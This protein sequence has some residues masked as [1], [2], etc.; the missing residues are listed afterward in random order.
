VRK[1]PE[2]KR[3]R[4]ADIQINIGPRRGGPG[5]G[6]IAPVKKASDPRK[7]LFRLLAFLG[8]EK[9]GLLYVLIFTVLSSI[10]SIF[11]PFLLGKA[12][13]DHILV[14]DPSGLAVIAIFMAAIYALSSLFQWLQ[15]Y[16]MIGVTQRTVRRLRQEVFDKYQTLPV[17]FFDTHSHG[18]LMSRVT[19]DINNIS[20]T[21]SESVTQLLSSLLSLG[22]IGIM[23][24]VLSPILALVSLTS[25]PLVVLVTGLIA[26]QSKKNFV[27]QQKALGELNGY[28][29]ERI[30]GEKVV[31][32]YGR[33]DFTI[34]QFQKINESY[35]KSAILAQIFAGMFGPVMNM[36]S[37]FGYAVVAFAG[38]WMT[39]EGMISVGL[40]ASFVVYVG[41]FNRPINQIAQ[42]YNSIQAALAGAERV[43]EVLDEEG[44]KKPYENFF[45]EKIKGKVELK[46]VDFSYDGKTIVLK[47]V[48]LDAQPGQVVALVG[49]TGAG[50]TT[51]VNL[52][53]KFYDIE[54]GTIYIDDHDI[55]SFDREQLRKKLGIVLQDTQL[56]MGTI[57]ENIRYGKPDAKD[58]E[59]RKVARMANAD[60]FIE[61]LPE[62]YDT[63]ISS[64][65]DSISKGQRQ[66]LAIARIMLLDPEIL[67][68][69]EA[70]S[71]VDTRTEM[72]IQEAMRNLMRGRTSFVVAH[73]LSTIKNADKIYVINNGEIIESGTH[74]ELIARGGFYKSLYTTQFS[75]PK[76]KTA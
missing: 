72:H 26:K 31:K 19:N 47:K 74:N 27:S 44:E 59:I 33:E 17:K 21:L 54:S 70:T 43:F 2:E 55:S 61:S 39:I 22:G 7:T 6:R 45:P 60:H 49:P 56:F 63:L 66:L 42:L 40:V 10:A 4:P 37:N 71:N 15:G 18:E 62:G 11:G 16:V 48:S 50:K 67:I 36:V 8:H 35:R 38:G 25:V 14:G 76:E 57:R 68:L 3:E 75:L 64:N 58:D 20:T 52:L 46:E 30:S 69:D 5:A 23:M 1:V 24:F 28:I 13:D 12:I 32:A 29:E 41:Q 53:T 9:K 65:A 34:E 73:R 51:I